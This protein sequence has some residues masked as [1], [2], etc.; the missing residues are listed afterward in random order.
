MFD[1]AAPL[2]NALAQS[3]DALASAASATSRA[4]T[5]YG[6]QRSDA[7]MAGVAEKAVFQE[8]LMNAMHARLA[9]IK[10]VTHG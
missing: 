7:A 10:S 3:R 9:E 1:V 4:Q 2:M 8:A 5:P 6:S